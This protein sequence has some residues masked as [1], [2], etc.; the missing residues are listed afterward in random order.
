MRR[1]FYFFTI[2]FFFFLSSCQLD[3]FESIDSETGKKNCD[4]LFVMYLDG[5]NTLAI[6]MYNKIKEAERALYDVSKSL[7]RQKVSIKV[8]A[9]LDLLDTQYGLLS[10]DSAIRETAKALKNYE[11]CGVETGSYFLEVGANTVNLGNKSYV[12]V[13][14][15][16]KEYWGDNTSEIV[17]FS[18]NTKIITKSDSDMS[19]PL[20]LKN[21]L[22]NVENLYNPKHR[23]LILSDHG[24]GPCGTEKNDFSVFSK[25]AFEDYSNANNS[26]TISTVQLGNI[27]KECG[28]DNQKID[29]ICYDNCFGGAVEEAYE[30]KNCADY[31]IASENIVWG[32]SFPVYAM[33]Y[34]LVENNVKIN[35]YGVNENSLNDIVMHFNVDKITNE[36]IGNN[37][38]ANYAKF[39]AQTWAASE[40]LNVYTSI[41]NYEHP[42]LLK[43][44]YAGKTKLGNDYKY[45]ASET[46]SLYDLNKISDVAQKM[47]RLAEQLCKDENQNL[48]DKL[49]Y[50]N[51]FFENG[52]KK[53]PIGYLNCEYVSQN[54]YMNAL[55]QPLTGLRNNMVN[56]GTNAGLCYAFNAVYMNMYDVGAFALN[57]YQDVLSTEEVK[58]SCLELMESL[59]NMI[60][61]SYKLDTKGNNEQ[62]TATKQKNITSEFNICDLYESNFYGISV[63]GQTIFDCPN[64]GV[65]PSWYGN[66]SFGKNC[67]NWAKLLK[68]M[69]DKN[70]RIM[71]EIN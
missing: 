69:E 58:K 57:V 38:P 64:K 25:N 27:L 20:T 39:I 37:T 4:W 61:Y 53:Y 49:T 6:E 44:D 9:F 51:H 66:L 1:F 59:Q 30:I 70:K 55:K 23:V 50:C 42:V 28:Y 22:I 54:Q 7:N 43:E 67:S 36:S 52:G 10:S 2:L 65:I 56:T 35:S 17:N 60:K 11:E 12:P 47:D 24:C 31:M 34:G 29:I 26:K 19:D 46:V 15:N 41:N 45:V 33:I 62:F 40:Y 18:K 63:M 68:L 21:F 8:V 16:P 3:S 71:N 32:S 48:R 14:K 5:D 13:I